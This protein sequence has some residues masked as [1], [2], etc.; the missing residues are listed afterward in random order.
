MPAVRAD[1]PWSPRLKKKKEKKKKKKELE[2]KDRD[3]EWE[4]GKEDRDPA[5]R[6][7]LSSL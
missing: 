1:G 4:G 2:K 6:W 7:D 5:R 3:V